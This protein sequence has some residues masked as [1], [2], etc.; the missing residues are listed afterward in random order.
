MAFDPL[1]KIQ[2]QNGRSRAGCLMGNE[3]DF[4][5]SGEKELRS[6]NKE[7]IAS[8]GGRKIFFG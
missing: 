3:E 8:E 1:Q 5:F 6:Q 7:L 4:L 2:K